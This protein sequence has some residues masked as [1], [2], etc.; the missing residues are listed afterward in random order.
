M[1]DGTAACHELVDQGA[2]WGLDRHRHA[3]GVAGPADEPGGKLLQRP[4]FMLDRG[5]PQYRAV[6]AQ[7]ADL[8]LPR[9]PIDADVEVVLSVRGAPPICDQLRWPVRA[10]GP[11]QALSAQLPTGCHETGER[12]GAQVLPWRSRAQGRH[13]R[14]PTR[15]PALPKTLR[16]RLP[17]G[18]G[19]TRRRPV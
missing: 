5:I 6:G 11:V 9:A 10:F 4:P 1:E 17:D 18:T 8:M 13:W 3:C 19:E 14:L 2:V 7:Q 12:V 15:P 16:S